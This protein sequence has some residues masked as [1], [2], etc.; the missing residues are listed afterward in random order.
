[1]HTGEHQSEGADASAAPGQVARRR[2][3]TPAFV[4]SFACLLALGAAYGVMQAREAGRRTSCLCHLM[5]LS[6]ALRNYES[7][8]GCFPPA[9]VA[10]SQG[11]PMHSWRV[12]LLPYLDRADLYARYSFDE[13]WDGPNNVK[14]LDE[15]PGVYA[16]PS[17]A[18]GE[19][20]TAGLAHFPEI[21]ACIGGAPSERGQ[22]M[23]TS[24]AAVLGPRCV[25]RGSNPAALSE[26]PDGGT[27]LLIGEVTDADIPWTKP[28]DVDVAQHPR[29]GD[30]MGFSSDHGAGV[31]FGFVDGRDRCVRREMSQRTVDA[32]YTRD[33][34]EPVSD[35]ELR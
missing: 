32:L 18:R 23:F 16:C 30:R 7:Q 27:T 35:E 15:M 10:D 33:G 19:R 14:L 8:Y 26:V 28:E 34:G 22:R 9:Y 31:N 5:N 20:R 21:I 2:L 29:L 24:Y 3:R 13:P 11:R 1:M 17:R 12:L 25:F 4:I 6:L